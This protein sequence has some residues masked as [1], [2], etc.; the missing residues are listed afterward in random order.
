MNPMDN[1]MTMI[2]DYIY[3]VLA[4]PKPTSL[5]NYAFQTNESIIYSEPIGKK[6]HYG[7]VVAYRPEHHKPEQRLIIKDSNGEEISINPQLARSLRSLIQPSLET[8]RRL[9]CLESKEHLNL[10][11]LMNTDIICHPPYQKGEKKPFSWISHIDHIV[12]IPEIG[13][14]YIGIDAGTLDGKVELDIYDNN[15]VI[16]NHYSLHV[17]LST[18]EEL[19]KL[20]EIIIDT[21]SFLD[22]DDY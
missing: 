8:R 2:T 5:K 21:S 6:P 16:T 18:Y 1:F 22:D 11:T 15:G 13:F 9:Y 17:P 7:T 14:I 4:R 10:F 3:S 19:L 20:N 12:A